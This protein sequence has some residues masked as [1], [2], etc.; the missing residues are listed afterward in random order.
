MLEVAEFLQLGD[1]ID[2]GR[3][4][5]CGHRECGMLLGEFVLRLLVVGLSLL[6]GGW[7]YRR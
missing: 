4:C 3:G 2:R 1:E 6:A 7:P 5:G